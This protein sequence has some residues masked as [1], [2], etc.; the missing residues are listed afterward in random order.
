MPDLLPSFTSYLGADDRAPA[1]ARS[2]EPDAAKTCIVAIAHAARLSA[3]GVEALSRWACW[4]VYAAERENDPDYHASPAWRTVLPVDKRNAPDNLA[5][6]LRRAGEPERV[7]REAAERAYSRHKLLGGMPLPSATY[8]P[9]L[10]AGTPRLPPYAVSFETLPTWAQEM[11][12]YAANL[13]GKDMVAIPDLRG[14]DLRWLRAY[15]ADFSGCDLSGCD[16]S[17]ADLR[18]ACLQHTIKTNTRFDHALR[19]VAPSLAHRSHPRLG[20]TDTYIEKNGKTVSG[21]GAGRFLRDKEILRVLPFARVEQREGIE[22]GYLEDGKPVIQ[23]QGLRGC[24]AAAAAMLIVDYGRPFDGYA[25]R[26]SNPG[27]D[28]S[29]RLDIERAGLVPITAEAASMEMLALQLER[30]GSA[31]VSAGDRELGSHAVV[32]DDV[33][34]AASRAQ[35]RDP[36]HGWA[37]IIPLNAFR[38]RLHFPTTLIH[39][40]LPDA[41]V[42][43]GGFHFQPFA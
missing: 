20:E 38:R 9:L 42:P 13:A 7:A 37:L 14:L 15:F 31:T 40:A 34:L 18:G 35:L 26:T 28:D 10:G 6:I 3:A 27:D 33:D 12:L 4:A 30:C 23:Q 29:I 19:G 17:H 2:D 39:A 5:R 25:V 11:A 41:S 8:A 36:F 21:H 43:G 24:A 22:I 32:V 16:F 1:P